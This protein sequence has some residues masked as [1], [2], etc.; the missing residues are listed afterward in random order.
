MN[1]TE[2]VQAVA[3]HT[4]LSNKQAAEA[5]GFALEAIRR[6]V[7]RVGYAKIDNIMLRRKPGGDRGISGTIEE[8]ETYKTEW[9]IRQANGITPRMRYITRREAKSRM[10]DGDALIKILI[11]ETCKESDPT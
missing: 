7:A 2:L 3:A 8:G 11:T 10:K 1:K 5:V 4:G 6:E 9:M